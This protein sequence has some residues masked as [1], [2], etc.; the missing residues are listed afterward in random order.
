VR[1]VELMFFTPAVL[2]I[3][4]LNSAR[5]ARPGMWAMIV[6]NA[7]NIAADIV[8]VLCYHLGGLGSAL[9]N[10]SGCVVAAATLVYT[11]HRHEIGLK[12]GSLTS[13]LIRSVSR[14]EI[15]A[16][17]AMAWPLGISGLLDNTGALVIFGL[18]GKAGSAGAANARVAYTV[19]FV[20]FVV[21]RSFAMGGQILI[22]RAAH[23][24]VVRRAI[25][26]A[27]FHAVGA[28]ALPITVFVWLFPTLT[29]ELFLSRSTLDDTTQPVQLMALVLPVMGA[30]LVLSAYVKAQGQTKVDMYANIAAVWMVQVPVAMLLIA[31]GWSAG[32]IV[33]SFGAYWAAR[34][35]MLILA[36]RSRVASS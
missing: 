10:V 5:L 24:E 21:L 34:A 29:S 18:I 15:F 1:S 3:G 12:L 13:M 20:V 30:A 27:T 36:R 22:G 11:Y 17:F 23:N 31:D 2:F 4:T 28:L 6:G 26:T 14:R 9:G 7:I 8:L 35:L 16:F 19:M 25:L 33:L 32:A